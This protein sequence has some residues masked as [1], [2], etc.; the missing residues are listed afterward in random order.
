MFYLDFDGPVA[1]RIDRKTYSDL[2]DVSTN[3]EVAMYKFP[4]ETDVAPTTKNT[5]DAKLMVQLLRIT[6]EYLNALEKHGF[7]ISR[8]LS[9]ERL[10]F[11]R[12]NKNK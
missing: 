12:I 7:D 2:K 6:D 9:P 3:K 10:A 8:I 1:K 4:V 11:Y 5:D